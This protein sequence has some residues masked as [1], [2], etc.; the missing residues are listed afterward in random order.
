M[1]LTN[2]RVITKK[3]SAS[4]ALKAKSSTLGIDLAYPRMIKLRIIRNAPTT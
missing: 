1:K 3:E 2:P 4:I